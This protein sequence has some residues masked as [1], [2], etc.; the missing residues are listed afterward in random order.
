MGF[1]SPPVPTE[2]L[3]SA[4]VE[5]PTDQFTLG[6]PATMQI[7]VNG[8]YMFDPS[9]SLSQEFIYDSTTMYTHT[10]GTFATQQD[11]VDNFNA[12]NGLGFEMSYDGPSPI[13]GNFLF[14]IVT[15]INSTTYASYNGNQIEI[16]YGVG[17]PDAGTF[18]GGINS[19]T[20]YVLI[21][22]YN[23][24]YYSAEPFPSIQDF[25][26]D[27]NLNDNNNN[28]GYT[29]EIV[30]TSGLNTLVRFTAPGAFEYNGQ[31]IE[32]RHQSPTYV[33]DTIYSGG[34]DTT[35]GTLTINLLDSGLSLVQTL[36]QDPTP[37]NYT[38]V[39]ELFG[40]LNTSPN[41]LDF[42]YV[43]LGFSGNG[44]NS[45]VD[46]FAYYNGF[47]I[48][49]TYEY[50]SGQ[51]SGDGDVN[52]TRELEGGIDPT[53]DEYEAPVEVNGNVGTFQNNEPCA[54]TIAEQECLSNKD[55]TNIIRHIDRIVK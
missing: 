53:L 19:T 55:I 51:Y 45:P 26:D 2:V 39:N 54:N 31:S 52:I 9:G 36:Y 20:G 13:P 14:T 44:F 50:V 22:G 37:Q 8:F 29:A 41:N 24:N 5:I 18:S 38:T 32:Y 30:G 15:T 35:V 34:F 7:D 17:E 40:R 46:S 1:V 47:N 11:L 3:A 33:Y 23:L 27:F 21:T 16:D 43:F 4:I 42:S 28:V 48:Q 49:I 12:N 10:G 6:S 25:I